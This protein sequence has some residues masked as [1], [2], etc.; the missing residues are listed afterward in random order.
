[1]TKKKM[2]ILI[3]FSLCV[4]TGCGKTETTENE[5]STSAI[6]TENIMTTTTEQT[7][8]L[9]EMT[10]TKMTT[11]KPETTTTEQ[12]TTLPET[13]TVIETIPE[14]LPPET[15][16]ETEA[17]PDY[18]LEEMEPEYLEYIRTAYVNT[19]LGGNTSI[20]RYSMEDDEIY[21]LDLSY[22]EPVD[23][24]AEV[25]EED[26]AV[27][28]YVGSGEKWGWIDETFLSDTVPPSNEAEV[29]PPGIRGIYGT[30]SIVPDTLE[31]R[32]SP[33]D[34]AEV[35]RTL[36]AGDTLREMGSNEGDENWVY[37]FIEGQFGWL[38]TRDPETG[39]KWI[40]FPNTISYKPAIYL[41]PEKKTDVSVKLLLTDAELST[42]YPKYQDGWNVTAYPDGKIVNKADNC[43]Y[44]YLFWDAVG[45]FN[46]DMSKGFCVKGQDMEKFL[47]EKLTLLGL[48]ESEMNEF[49]VYWLPLTEHNAY[50]L[51]SFQ[52]DVYTEHFKLN[53]S[54]K[55]D[56]LLRVFA[57]FKPVE[58]FV[59]IQPQELNG[60]E[61][62]GFTVVEWGGSII[63]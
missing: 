27:K 45:N 50:N 63:E 7:T 1:M 18:K 30:F 52:T 2:L 11:T 34:E 17:I 15:V 5:Q 24:Y 53:I 8:T 40:K 25:V 9:E 4:L 61:R 48:T 60:F 6:T 31:L 51:I 36:S 37:A 16:T 14:T 43:T 3:C 29:T 57:A 41:Y 13:T 33:D 49:I 32:K 39:E 10:T 44:E 26:G 38:R 46:Y 19:R 22:G 12:T 21:Y 55:P 56:S 42:T 58:Q 35:I 23:I 28:A 59:R 20:S 47:R 54:P 62:K